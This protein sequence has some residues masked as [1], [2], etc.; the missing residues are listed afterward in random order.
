MT[1]T[2]D[3]RRPVSVREARRSR[4]VLVITGI[5]VL[6]I[7]IGRMRYE[8]G[9]G[10]SEGDRRSVEILQMVEHSEYWISPSQRGMKLTP[11]SSYSSQ[12]IISVMKSKAKKDGLRRDK[13]DES[14]VRQIQRLT[15]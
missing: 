14:S 9:D 8:D 12:T 10:G 13:C 7:A 4:G 15:N 6:G 5:D 11:V 2:K 1:A 3:W